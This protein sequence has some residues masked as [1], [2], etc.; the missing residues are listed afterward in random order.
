MKIVVAS[1][2]Q[3]NLAA[4][5]VLPECQYDQLWCLGDLFDYGPNPREVVG[6]VR[7]NATAVVRGNH[8]H[9]AGFS[10]EPVC[11]EQYKRLTAEPLQCTL[12][13]CTLEE[14]YRV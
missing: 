12:D 3:A 14:D 10:V 7:T 6:W 11:S 8:D 4:L 5:E 2:T 9:A 1:K 13:V